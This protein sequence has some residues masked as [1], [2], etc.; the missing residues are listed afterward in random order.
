[1]GL[2]VLD[3]QSSPILLLLVA[4]A[5]VLVPTLVAVLGVFFQ[6]LLPLKQAQHIQLQLALVGL[7]ME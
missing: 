5:A 7:V 4:A 1:L 3:L 6:E 2:A